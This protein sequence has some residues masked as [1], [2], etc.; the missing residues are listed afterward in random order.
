[1]KHLGML[2]GEIVAPERP[3]M[4]LRGSHL[5]HV[6]TTRG[7]FWIPQVKEGDHVRQGDVLGHV[8]ALQ[9]FEVAETVRAPYNGYVLGRPNSPVVNFG[10]DVVNLCRTQ[11]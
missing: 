8:Y 6:I 5:D 3:Q 1:M 11:E 4:T 9:T 10:D 2:S 7:G